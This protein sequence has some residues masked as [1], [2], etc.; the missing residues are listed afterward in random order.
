MRK[1]CREQD[2]YNALGISETEGWEKIISLL[3]TWRERNN[4]LKQREQVTTYFRPASQI[5]SKYRA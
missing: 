2:M 1:V 3:A 5:R 4:E